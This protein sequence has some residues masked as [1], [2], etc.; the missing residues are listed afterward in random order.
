MAANELYPF[1][2]F[3]SKNDTNRQRNAELP[4][5]DDS[6]NNPLDSIK[7]DVDSQLRQQAHSPIVI[8]LANDSFA[9]MTSPHEMRP[10][11]TKKPKKKE[12]KQFND[13][14]RL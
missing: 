10:K 6:Y 13:K 1:K 7:V 5:A 12:A 4:D 2:S 9:P 8:T 3:G 14:R 11:L